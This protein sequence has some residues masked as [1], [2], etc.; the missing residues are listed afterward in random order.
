M[1]KNKIPT[2]IINLKKDTD[3]KEHMKE[4]CKE[5][6]LKVEFIEAV[7][8]KELSQEKVDSV[9]SKDEAIKEI[10]RELSLGEIGCFL[11]HKMI[12]QRMIDYDIEE[13][14]I[15]ED[16]IEFDK[17]LLLVLNQIKSISDRWELILLGHHTES[18]R[19]KD[20][21]CSIWQQKYIVG[22]YK[23]VRPCEIGYGAYGYMINKDGAS[24]LLKQL[25]L[26]KPIDHF[27][28][29]SSYLNVYAI[30]P[31]PIR[32]EAYLSD[33]LHS[34]DERSE[35]QKEYE[36]QMEHRDSIL[37]KIT[38]TLG[39]YIFLRK[40]RDELRM[41]INRIKPLREYV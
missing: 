3:K 26:T 18:S 17:N 37:K 35:L 12:Y 8:G 16:D 36:N 11:S 41:L 10:G 25:K 29:N 7:N 23:L 24:K 15:L 30:N 39:M 19:D 9:Y 4:L 28:G 40:V 32:I 38:K 20:T 14:L 5:F 6:N 27:T 33:N 2:F 21:L 31:A 1:Q 22:K 34:M 13:A